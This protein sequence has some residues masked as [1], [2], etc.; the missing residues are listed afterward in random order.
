VREPEPEPEPQSGFDAEGRGFGRY[1]GQEVAPE[2]QEPEPEPEPEPINEEE[3]QIED[4][5]PQYSTMIGYNPD[6]DDYF[7]DNYVFDNEGRIMTHE[8]CNRLREYCELNPRRCYLERE[9]LEKYVRICIMIAKTALYVDR[10]YQRT[11]HNVEPL[12]IV[13]PWRTNAISFRMNLD[14]VIK[15]LI[16]KTQMS[17]NAKNILLQV[18]E[19]MPRLSG[20]IILKPTFIFG[21]QDVSMVETFQNNIKDFVKALAGNPNLME[22]MIRRWREGMAAETNMRPKQIEETIRRFIRNL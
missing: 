15:T 11:Q 8:T 5:L 7:L 16:P 19:S 4:I 2:G 20:G 10:F 12:G 9:F 3:P 14:R 6:M 13:E 21:R 1:H 22:E 17:Q 18:I